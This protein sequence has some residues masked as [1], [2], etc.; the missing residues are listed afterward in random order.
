MKKKCVFSPLLVIF[1][2]VILS[3]VSSLMHFAFA[4]SGKS[5]VV[6]LVCPVN[7][8]VWEHLKLMFFPLLVWWVVVYFIKRNKCNINLEKWIV[9]A[10]TSLVVAPLMVI[11]LFYAYTGA[12]GI[13]SVV[14][15]IL[16]VPLCFFIAIIVGAA[17]YNRLNPD[18]VLVAIS[19]AVIVAI[20]AMFIVFTFAPPQLPIFLDT[21]SGTYGIKN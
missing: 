7:E 11:L 3:V 20:F 14:I 1:S 6:A 12:F 10:A 19:I 13:E 8:S 16:M 2:I 21:P 5:A 4:F 17:V 15:D 9:S 18:K